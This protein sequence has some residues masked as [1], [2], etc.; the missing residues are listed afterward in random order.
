[1]NQQMKDVA[2]SCHPIIVTAPT[3]T[4]ADNPYSTKLESSPLGGVNHT[5]RLNPYHRLQLR[6]LLLLHPILDYIQTRPQDEDLSLE[7]L[8]LP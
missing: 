1:M 5:I 7:T 4:V 8:L 3:L 6:I 2:T